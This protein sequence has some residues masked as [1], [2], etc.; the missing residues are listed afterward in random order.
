MRTWGIISMLCVAACDA[1]PSGPGGAQSGSSYIVPAGPSTSEYT[2]AIEP[3]EIEREGSSY[4]IGYNLPLLL[5]GQSQRVDLRGSL[6]AAG[7]IATL[8]GDAGTGTCDL[9]PGNGAMLRCDERLTGIVVDLAAVRTLAEAMNPQMAPKWISIA[10]RFSSE[11]IGI[12]E[13]R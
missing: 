8:L 9:Q 5:V 2:Y 12:L 7:K 3:A 11:P 10:E 6:D 13:V 1:G 4:K